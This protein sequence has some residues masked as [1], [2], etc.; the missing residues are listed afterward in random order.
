MGYVVMRTA[1]IALALAVGV[2]T[3][4]LAASNY[5]Y[6]STNRYYLGS[7][8]IENNKVWVSQ[9][10]GNV[11]HDPAMDNGTWWLQWVQTGA[12]GATGPQGSQGNAGPTG[13]AGATGVTGASGAGGAAGPT[14]PTGST[15]VTGATGATGPTGPAAAPAIMEG[16]PVAVPTVAATYWINPKQAA[17]S[18]TE[19][20]S[21]MPAPVTATYTQIACC[22]TVADGGGKT[23]A[24]TLVD[25]TSACT[26]NPPTCTT[27]NATC[28][29]ATG[30]SCPVTQKDLIVIKDVTTSVTTR[31]AWCAISP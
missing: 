27:S 2:A 9:Q 5:S 10:D 21:E 26:S 31:N 11:G 4:A 8:A 13:P 3:F 19:A 17:Q 12:T 16:V 28:C 6:D 25:A 18:T 23:S 30:E 29:S 24:F 15:G 14:G 7:L 1:I 20:T 22:Q